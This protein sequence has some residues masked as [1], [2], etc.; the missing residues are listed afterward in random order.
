MIFTLYCL[1]AAY[2]IFCTAPFN[3]GIFAAP[4]YFGKFSLYMIPI[5]FLVG[6]EWRRREIIKNQAQDGWYEALLRDMAKTKSH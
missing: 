1:G 5:Y 3:A 6:R 2:F 4:I